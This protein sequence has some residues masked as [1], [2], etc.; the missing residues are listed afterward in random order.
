MQLRPYQS[1]AVSAV[2]EHLRQR[3]DNPAVVIPTGGGKTPV[4]ATIC[5]D[6]VQTWG[7]RA[8]VLAHVKEL[9]EQTLEKLHAVAPDLPVGICSA[10][11]G[12]KDLQYAVTVGGIQSIYKRACDLGPVDLIIV[13]EAH[14][15][16]ADDEGMYRRFIADAKVVCPHARVIGLTATPYRMKS[17]HICEPDNILNHV[18]YEVGVRELIVGGY[19]SKLKTRAGTTKADTSD[20]HVRAGEFVASEVEQLMD[21][22][23][24]VRPACQEVLDLTRDRRSVLIFAS[25][26]GHGKHIVETLEANHGVECGFVEG[27]TPSAER[28]Q[29]LGRFK[30]GSLKYLCNVNVLTTGFDAPNVDCVV[31]LRPTMSPGLYYQ[32]V[33]RGFRLAPGKE[34][35]LVLDYG[36][37]VLR[38]GPVDAVHVPEPGDG[39]GE[40]P[41]KECPECH[42]LIALGYQ[43]C[44]E[45]GFK[46]EPPVKK[47]MD[48][49]ATSAEILTPDETSYEVRETH[50]GVHAKRDAAPN[51]PRTLRV[52]Y[53]VGVFEHKS[54]WVCLEHPAGSFALRKA[55]EWWR[56]RSN[57]P[58]PETIEDAV[59]VAQAGALARTISIT[60]CTPVGERYDRISSHQLGD[61]PATVVLPNRSTCCPDCGS[62]ELIWREGAVGAWPHPAKEL[63]QECDRILRWVPKAELERDSRRAVTSAAATLDDDIPF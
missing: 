40:A 52:D 11:L 29:I 49:N 1:E 34:D 6:A 56:K 39:T 2:Y 4:I 50:Y 46:F 48:K 32:M 42:A 19:L 25:G 37:N 5:R 55:R 24:L 63:C 30:A 7:G 45:C 8:V 43:A 26:I 53:R 41:A 57:A 61:V 44:P 20:L 12:R 33:G 21:R 31:L 59:E 10:G 15:V 58:F 14:M 18:C 13:D 3:D 16:P 28:A 36:S 27:N 23:E 17:G 51:A 22:M 47:G 35:C 54:E 60:V 62:E 9:L 38:H